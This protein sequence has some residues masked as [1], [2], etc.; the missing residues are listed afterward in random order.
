M[1]LGVDPNECKMGLSK[2]VRSDATRREK[3]FKRTSIPEPKPNGHQ[4]PKPSPAK[5]I[6][7]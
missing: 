4:N 6:Q 1:P 7:D 5:R 3:A 2:R